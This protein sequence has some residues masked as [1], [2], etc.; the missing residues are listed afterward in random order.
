[1]P[2]LGNGRHEGETMLPLPLTSFEEYLFS[3]D[4]LAHP[5]ILTFRL[6]FSGLLDPESFEK[7]LPVVV[8][9]H[10]L[11]RA[12]VHRNR[13]GRLTWIDHPDW[14]PIIQ[15]HAKGDTS[16]FPETSFMDITREPGLRVWVLDRDD[17]NDLALQLHHCCTDGKGLMLFIEDLLTAYAMQ[18]NCKKTGLVL[19]NFEEGTLRKRGTPD[20]SG[21]KNIKAL[22]M[23]VKALNG[24]KRF[25]LR[26]PAQLS[27]NRIAVSE[28]APIAK[29]TT[30]LFF[31]FEP[32][33]TRM[34]TSTAKLM[35]ATINDLLLRD[36]FLAVGAWRK[37]KGVGQDEDWL[38]FSIPVDLRTSME[39]SMPMANSI[40]L[41]FLDRRYPDFAEKENL[42]TSIQHQMASNKT[43]DLKYT[44]I[45]SAGLSRLLPKSRKRMTQS[46]KCYVTTCFSNLGKVLDRTALPLID[47]K[48]V[49]GNVL[50]ESV[51]LV[52]PPLRNKM[53]AAFIVHTYAGRLN[54]ALNYNSQV[55]SEHDTRNLLE[56]FI[57]EIRRTVQENHRV[58][59]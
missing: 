36:L 20:L 26:S 28:K 50:L 53:D 14:H 37:K 21:W 18:Q 38:R 52:A 55:L 7:A 15:W 44:F 57:L 6:R 56:T 19:R 58:K 35:H 16:G 9:R 59:T 8:R 2:Y 30:A 33:E 42:L 1:M 41:V 24:V 11:L 34:L 27:G 32:Q 39:N 17:G 49:A 5:M 31:T 43:T 48:V 12:T 3:D 4:S 23:Q 22:L 29:Q 47:G 46:N 40:S 25:L 54:L 51:D 10:P 13:F 45:F